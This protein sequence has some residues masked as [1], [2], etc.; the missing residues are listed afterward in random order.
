MLSLALFIYGVLVFGLIMFSRET[1]A[2][3]AK[4]LAGDEMEKY[5]VKED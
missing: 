5:E 4:I 2:E 1:K 3:S